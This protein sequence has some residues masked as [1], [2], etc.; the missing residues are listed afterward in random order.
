MA[1]SHQIDGHGGFFGCIA[2]G[3]F[4]YMPAQHGMLYQNLS[5]RWKGFFSFRGPCF[6]SGF[7]YGTKRVVSL[8]AHASDDALM[9][10]NH[11]VTA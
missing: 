5:E 8:G 9:I 4:A 1:S 10:L 3:Q 6:L 2:K 7:V 11:L